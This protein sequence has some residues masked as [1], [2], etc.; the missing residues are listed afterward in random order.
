MIDEIKKIF[1]DKNKNI[2]VS[3]FFHGDPSTNTKVLFF[4]SQENKSL[5]IVKMVRKPEENDLIKRE[6]D[7]INY[8]KS[9]GLKVPEI[10]GIGQ[11]NGLD[12]VCQEVLQGMPVGKN[13]QIKVFPQILNYH[14]KSKKIK[15]I[16]IKEIL[17]SIKTLEIVP[18][19]EMSQILEDLSLRE[20]N[21]IWVANQHGDLTYKNLI[22]KDGEISF[23]DFENFGLHS[24]LGIDIIHYMGRMVDA[25]NEKGNISEIISYFIETSRKFRNNYDLDMPDEQCRDLFLLDMLFEVLKK[26]LFHMRGDVTPL[27]KNI[28][29]K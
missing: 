11:I 19:E 20:N 29:L 24:V 14:K 4:V 27:I 18:N 21:K 5:G 16:K 15:E 17:N 25:N 23:I 10:L 22:I 28:W 3:K 9:M 26:T 1:S 6:I 7:G 8:F 13:E 12:Y 2:K